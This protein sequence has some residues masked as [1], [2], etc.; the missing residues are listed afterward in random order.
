M[1]VESLVSRRVQEEIVPERER[2]KVSHIYIYTL[3][4]SFLDWKGL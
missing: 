1:E 3:R 2:E 4:Q